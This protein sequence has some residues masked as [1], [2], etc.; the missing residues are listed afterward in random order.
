MDV[1][2][3]GRSPGRQGSESRQEAATAA[4]R[5]IPALD[6]VRGVAVVAVLADHAGVPGLSGGFIGVD[7]FFVL[8]GFLIT[9]L[10]LE[11]QARTGRVRLAAFWARRA[12]RLLPAAAVMVLTVGVC[13]RLFALDSTAGLRGDALAALGWVAN[14]RFAAGAP[15]TS[16]K[17]AP[18]PRC[19]T[20]GPWG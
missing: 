5:G 11:E 8:S 6:G 20:P 16:A 12:R 14:W 15:T 2:V 10:L 9:S 4:G 17:G 7:V 1:G 3:P 18:L 19:S 13:Q